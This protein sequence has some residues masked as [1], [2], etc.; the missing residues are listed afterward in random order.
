M[1]D[2]ARADRFAPFDTMID[3]DRALTILRDATAGADDGDLFL[4]RAPG[5]GDDL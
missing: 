1:T 3:P 2:A 5:R 4:E